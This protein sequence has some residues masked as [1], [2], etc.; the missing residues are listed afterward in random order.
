MR[1]ASPALCLFRTRIALVLFSVSFAFVEVAVVIYLRGLYEP[2]H[3]TLYPDAPSDGLFPILQPEQLVAAG[4]QYE[5]WM[6]TELVR[7]AATLAMLAAIALAVARNVRQWFAAF[8]IAFGLWDIFFYVWLRVLI[9]WPASLLEWDLLFLLPVP[10]VGPV[11]APVLVAASM[12]FAGVVLLKRESA[13]RPIRLTLV[14]WAAILSAGALVVIAFCWD[15]RN[16]MGGGIPHTFNWPLLIIGETVGIVAFLHGA[17][18]RTSGAD[19]A[20]R[21]NF[22]GHAKY[23]EEPSGKLPVPEDVH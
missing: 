2:L 20:A 6:L 18:K 4:P 19:E 16:I 10:W 7:E 5:G 1:Q 8:M 14:H 12:I 17:T 23:P 15:F 3:A 13:D 21:A 22:S 9:G 11:I